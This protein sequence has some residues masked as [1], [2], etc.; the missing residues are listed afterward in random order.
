[1]LYEIYLSIEYKICFRCLIPECENYTQ[2]PLEYKPEWL[3]NAVPFQKEKPEKCTRYEPQ[4][5]TIQECSADSFNINK[6]KTCDS[7]V[8]KDNSFKGIAQD[9]RK[10]IN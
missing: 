5:E 6:T 7:F 1:M 2:Y 9:V 10:L 4:I 8:F 3:E